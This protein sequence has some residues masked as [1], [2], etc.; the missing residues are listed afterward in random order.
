MISSHLKWLFCIYFWDTL[1]FRLCD[2]QVHAVKFQ[3]QTAEEKEAWI[4]ALSDGINRAKNKVFDE[5]HCVILTLNHDYLF[6][7]KGGKVREPQQ[8]VIAFP[9]QG[10]KKMLCLQ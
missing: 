1:F 9:T 8:T 3:A 7:L 10:L 4:K 6:K 2:W 5:V